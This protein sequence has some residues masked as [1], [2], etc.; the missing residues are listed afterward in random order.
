MVSMSDGENT[1]MY[2]TGWSSLKDG[3]EE[4]FTDYTDGDKSTVANNTSKQSDHRGLCR[5]PPANSRRMA[6]SGT[7]R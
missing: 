2:H 4:D 3:T 6:H 1:G 7:R 5:R